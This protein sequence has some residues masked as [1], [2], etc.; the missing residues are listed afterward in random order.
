MGLDLT[1]QIW[2]SYLKCGQGVKWKYEQTLKENITPNWE[3]QTENIKRNHKNIK[4]TCNYY[5]ENF[6][7]S[8]PTA[9]WNREKKIINELEDM[10][11]QHI[12]NKKTKDEGKWTENKGLNRQDQAG[13]YQVL[14]VSEWKLW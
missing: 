7:I 9:N 6:N 3:F 2:N 4:W 1:K 10:T 12:K 5:I 14:G 13:Q 11:L 8:V